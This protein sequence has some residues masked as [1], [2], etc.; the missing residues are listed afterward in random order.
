MEA[1]DR[2]QEVLKDLDTL[3][4]M[5]DSTLKKIYE[6]GEAKKNLF[7]H[8]YQLRRMNF[9]EEHYSLSLDAVESEPLLHSFDTMFNC[10]GAQYISMMF[11]FMS[12]PEEK[13]DE[14]ISDLNKMS[15]KADE[16]LLC[17]KNLQFRTEYE[18][19]PG[20][21]VYQ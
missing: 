2:H 7:I 9:P 5:V 12:L 15:K 3:Q 10:K 6:V 20:T 16:V 13:V 18:T 4:K 19:T 8:L 11:N 17:I 21:F 1:F 14:Y